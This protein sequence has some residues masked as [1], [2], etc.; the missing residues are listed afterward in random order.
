MAHVTGRNLFGNK[1]RPLSKHWRDLLRVYGFLP[2]DLSNR[3]GKM[4]TPLMHLRPIASE[5][6]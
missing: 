5:F 3:V 4:Q 1:T 2:I 6:L